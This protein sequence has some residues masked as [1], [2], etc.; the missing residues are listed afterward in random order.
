MVSQAPAAPTQRVQA[1]VGVSFSNAPQGMNIDS[2]RGD[3]DAQ[4]DT[5]IDYA[6]VGRGPYAYDLDSF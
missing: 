3:R 2:I 4:V 1:R 6:R 5:S